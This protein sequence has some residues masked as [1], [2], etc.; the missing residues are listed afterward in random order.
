ARSDTAL[1][2]I[3]T[4]FVTRLELGQELV[5]A[6]WY[7]RFPSWE[8]DLRRLFEV[9]E[10]L[11]SST[12]DGLA[13]ASSDAASSSLLSGPNIPSDPSG[14]ANYEVLEK[15]GMGAMGV[16]YKVRQPPPLKRI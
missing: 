10:V 2:V 15:V 1:E 14:F 4:E 3:Y 12:T 13:G 6:D 9:H 7:A 11:C 16:V 5:L 8:E